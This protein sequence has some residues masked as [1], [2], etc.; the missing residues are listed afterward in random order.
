MKTW[1]LFCVFMLRQE[2][3]RG[4]EADADRS[5]P[6]G[7]LVAKGE[8]VLKKMQWGQARA[9]LKTL[10]RHLNISPITAALQ[11]ALS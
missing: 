10:L 6:F 9:D 3:L 1:L 2:G 7:T 4:E 11:A 5:G 8:L